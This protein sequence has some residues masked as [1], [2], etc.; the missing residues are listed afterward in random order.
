[1]KLRQQNWQTAT[2]KSLATFNR[3]LVITFRRKHWH[4][5]SDT[6]EKM[7]LVN[8]NPLEFRTENGSCIHVLKCKWSSSTLK[9]S[10]EKGGKPKTGHAYCRLF[11]FSLY[12]VRALPLLPLA[13][14]P[15]GP[16][17]WQG[18]S[19]IQSIGDTT[20]S[21]GSP[22][23]L[24]PVN[25]EKERDMLEM[26]CLAGIQRLESADI[27]LL[28]SG[29]MGFSSWKHRKL[30]EDQWMDD[31]MEWNVQMFNSTRLDI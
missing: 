1:M 27:A 8:V 18:G 2:K 19:P 30:S 20:Q 12:R 6:Y 14:E 25:P 28:H 9:W 11:F 10:E 23:L 29:C 13:S 16:E 24:S 5:W 7:Y 15:S 31:L 22:T 26:A 3:V 17:G 21:W 4:K